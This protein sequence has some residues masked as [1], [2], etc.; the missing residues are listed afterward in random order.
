VEDGVAV[1]LGGVLDDFAALHHESYVFHDGDVGE[2]IGLPDVLYQW[3][4]SV[5]QLSS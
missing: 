4:V 2:G 3:I 5:A 1:G